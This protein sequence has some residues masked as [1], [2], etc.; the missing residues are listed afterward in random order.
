MNER[1][2]RLVMN[3]WVGVGICLVALV[4]WWRGEMDRMMI[5]TQKL[6]RPSWKSL[7]VHNMLLLL[8]M[9]KGMLS[10]VV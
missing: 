3:V 10:I 8:L 1:V 2:G 9:Y 4:G 6:L 7:R 5:L